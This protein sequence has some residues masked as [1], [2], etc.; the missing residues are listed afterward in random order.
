MTQLRSIYERWQRL[1]ED[2]AAISEDLKELFAE[3]KANGYEPKALRIAFRLKAKSEGP[4]A[5]EAAETAA[6]VETY[7]AALSFDAGVRL[8]RASAPA[9]VENIEKSDLGDTGNT[10]TRVADEPPGGSPEKPPAT[11]TDDWPELPPFLDR[12]KG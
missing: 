9:R 3:A 10:R 12:S 7:I 1:E 4:D 8:T 6:L 11:V 2:K 5:A